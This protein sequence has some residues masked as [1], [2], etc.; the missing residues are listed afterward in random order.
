[1]KARSLLR[2]AWLT[3]SMPLGGLAQVVITETY[4]FSGGSLPLSPADGTGAPASDTRT[5]SGSAITSLTDVNVRFTLTNPAQAGA[6]NGDY[7]VS[8]QHSSGFSVLL[9]RAGRR[10]G[11]LPS[12]TLGYGDNGFDITF[13]DQAAS[14][15]IHVYRSTL[16]GG[17]NST[18]V[19]PGFQLPLTGTWAPDGRSTSP[20]SVLN[21]DP[22]NALLS[23]FNGLEADG[24]WTLQ[25][26]DLNAGGAATLTSWSITL[27]GINA[28]PEPGE[29]L[30]VTGAAL[31]TLAGWRRRL[32]R[33]VRP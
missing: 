33:T 31:L 17:N 13:D 25:L 32:G 16:S 8:L 22:R 3:A 18:P 21:T 29:T 27:A 1:M 24:T 19:D 5:V 26:V 11:S 10:A 20:L 4:S 14:G 6:F 2:L 28:V 23:A 9:N 30:V 12:Q 15:D 7:Y